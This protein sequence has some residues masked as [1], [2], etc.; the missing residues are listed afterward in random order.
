EHGP[1]QA[2]AVAPGPD[3]H[4]SQ[5][6]RDR[7]M[8]QAYATLGMSQQQFEGMDP[9]E[10]NTRINAAYAQMYMDN[11]DV[12]KWAGMASYASETVGVGMMQA[13]AVNNPRVRQPPRRPRG[14]RPPP[15]VRRRDAPPAQD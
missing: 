11:P 15:A 3:G 4:P 8:S 13:G 7:Y 12:M 14:A 9:V 2:P 1:A 6:L 10:R 5:S